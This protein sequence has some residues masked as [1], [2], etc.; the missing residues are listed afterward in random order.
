M[1]VMEATE[2]LHLFAEL[3]LSLFRNPVH[4][5]HSCN[6]AIRKVSF[7]HSSKAPLPY[8]SAEIISRF[9]DL[10]VAESPECS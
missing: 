5:L 4:S 10:R 7:V 8:D 6:K 1:P 9:L 3:L 2:K